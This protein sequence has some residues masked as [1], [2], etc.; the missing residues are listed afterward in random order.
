MIIPFSR[1]AHSDIV[2]RPTDLRNPL[3]VTCEMMHAP[4]TWQYPPWKETHLSTDGEGAKKCLIEL[5]ALLGKVRKA[6]V[7][8]NADMTWKRC[9]GMTSGKDAFRRLYQAL[10]LKQGEG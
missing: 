6:I 4:M 3:R 8:G 2:G 1:E 7:W 10:S 9:E 5:L